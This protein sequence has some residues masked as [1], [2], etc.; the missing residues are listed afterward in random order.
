MQTLRGADIVART[1]EALGVTR[2]FTLSG[3]HIMPVFDALLE[4]GISLVHVR[5]EAAC[6]HMADAWGRL[7]GEVGV[8]LVTGGQGHTNGAAALTTALAADSP[9][10]LL[11]GHAGLSELG[12]GAFQELAQADIARPM[13]KAAWT[14]GSV[15]SLGPDLA[16][17]FRIARE[18]RPGPVHLSLPVDLLETAVPAAAV[19][20]PDRAVAALRVAEPA[21]DLVA[22]LLAALAGAERPLIACGPALC[23]GSGRAAMA[24]LEESLGLPVVGMESPRGINDPALGA[25]AEVLARA[26]LLVL[27]GK[28]LDFTLRFGAAPALAPDCRFAIVDPDPALLARAPADRLAVSGL[29]DPRP[30]VA[31]MTARATALPRREAWHRDARAALAYRPPAWADLRGIEGRLHPVELCRAVAAF[32]EDHPDGTLICDGGEIGQWPQ[33]LVRAGR[34][35]INGVSGTI[36]ASI[37]F[38]LAAALERPGAPVVAVLGDGTF[39]FHMAEFDTAVRYRIPFIAVVGNDA[40]WN[41]EHQ[42]QLRSYGPERTRHCDLLPTRYDTVVQALGG[43]GALVTEAAAFPAALEAAQASGLPACVN[44]M[45]ESVP[46][47]V[48]RRPG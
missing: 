42:I 26:D 20:I 29:A 11:S 10:L 8:A 32:L 25:F 28:P 46:A 33:A 7:T 45:I 31:A 36:G 19:R 17:A 12:R 35:L 16:R 4:T 13:T 14:A 6:V 24:A 3:N 27:L 40:R 22:D 15:A 18:G 23:D 30:V 2:I 41:A 39:G 9:V 37:P 48:I 38:A 47:P 44:V 43:F 21:P 1:L 5:H 34:R